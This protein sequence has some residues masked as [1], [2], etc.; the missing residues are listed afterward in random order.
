MLCR[1]KFKNFCHLRKKVSFASINCILRYYNISHILRI[2][3]RIKKI[4]FDLE[5]LNF[6]SLEDLFLLYT[7][8]LDTYPAKG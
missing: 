2:R 8:K 3:M 7:V 1:P 4:I 6:L 5:V